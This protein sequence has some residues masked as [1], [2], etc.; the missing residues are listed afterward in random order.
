MHVAGKHAAFLFVW[1]VKLTFSR[2]RQLGRMDAFLGLDF[3]CRE[4][5]LAAME[6]I[7]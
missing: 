3:P 4:G 7:R 2:G 5:I 1:L 6:E